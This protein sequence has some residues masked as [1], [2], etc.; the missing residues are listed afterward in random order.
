MLAQNMNMR[1]FVGLICFVINE[2]LL[3]VYKLFLKTV[4][5]LMADAETQSGWNSENQ[6][7]S[8]SSVM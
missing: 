3:R 6:L 1:G 8:S 2:K 4:L 7:T 5:K